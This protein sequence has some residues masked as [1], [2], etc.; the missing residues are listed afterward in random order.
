MAFVQI[1]DVQT[2]KFDEI[3]ALRKEWDGKTAGERTTRRRLITRDRND[4]NRYLIIV[5]FD[6]YESAMENSNRP[7]TQELAS[8]MQ[9]LTTSITFADLD[10]IED[11]GD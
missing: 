4:P 8:R 7:E 1:M 2:D 11:L 9:A 6:S 5:E 3:Q 10:V